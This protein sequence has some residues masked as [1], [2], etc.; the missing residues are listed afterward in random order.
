MAPV[1]HT[2]RRRCRMSVVTVQREDVW[3]NSGRDRV[4]AWLYRPAGKGDA[5]LLGMGHGRGAVRTM[6]LDAAAERLAAAVSACR[7]FDYRNFGDS[8]GAPRQLLD[9]R[10]QLQDWTVAVAYGR[11]LAGIDHNR[12]GLWGPSFLGG[13]VIATAARLPRIAAVG[14]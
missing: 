3:F 10:M 13:P 8:E 11:T 14:S 5:P 6:R 7:V 12:I 4:S 2:T 9:I 1:Y